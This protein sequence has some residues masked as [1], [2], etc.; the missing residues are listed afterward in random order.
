MKTPIVIPTCNPDKNIEDVFSKYYNIES[1]RAKEMN[2]LWDELVQD[3]IKAIEEYSKNKEKALTQSI[4]SCDYQYDEVMQYLK[5]KRRF[6]INRLQFGNMFDGHIEYVLYDNYTLRA[7]L[8]AI[9][10]N[11]MAD[12]GYI[13]TIESYKNKQVP[14]NYHKNYSKYFQWNKLE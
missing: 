4:Q 6:D 13:P 12:C 10:T 2:A 8:L 14:F 11:T 1:Q 5:I 9:E 7:F 3:E